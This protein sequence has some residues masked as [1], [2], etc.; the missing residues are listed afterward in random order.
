MSLSELTRQVVEWADQI[1]PQRKP[2]DTVIKTV[3]ETSE[4][5]DAV[6]NK[7]AA[8]V[9]EELGDLVILLA[10]IGNMYGIN[11]IDAGFKKMNINRNRKWR[12]EDGVI[13]RIRG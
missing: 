9:E 7:D 4:L 1:N 8:A 10:D 6:I 11:I 12:I 2:Q 13:R 5:L 3:S